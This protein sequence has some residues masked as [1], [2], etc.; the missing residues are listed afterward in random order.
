MSGTNTEPISRRKNWNVAA[1]MR[2]AVAEGGSTRLRSESVEVGDEGQPRDRH[3]DHE[4]DGQPEREPA[5]SRSR[6]ESVDP[7][8]RQHPNGDPDAHARHDPHP[9]PLEP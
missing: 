4:I 1:T 5:R 2:P 8:E 7:T 6:P 3:R 9:E